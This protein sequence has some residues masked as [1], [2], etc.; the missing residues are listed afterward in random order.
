MIRFT[1]DCGCDLQARESAAGE[2][3]RCPEC[4]AWVEVPP[5]APDHSSRCCPECGSRSIGRITSRRKLKKKLPA[6][7]PLAG[8]AGEWNQA[9]VF[10]LPRECRRCG[11][12][13]IPG[14]PPWSGVL[15]MVAG[16]LLLLFFLGLPIYLYFF[17]PAKQ[18]NEIVYVSGGLVL[19]SLAL[20]GYGYHVARSGSR[21][22]RILRAGRGEDD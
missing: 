16:T 7:D 6:G 5:P 20:I 22:P 18:P 17:V 21:R 4:G 15:L 8:D 2:H 3:V 1:C 12:I 9:F 10:R 11:A 13:W 14:L 19:G